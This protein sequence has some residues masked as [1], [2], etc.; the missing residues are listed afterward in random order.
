M[1]V[2]TPRELKYKYGDLNMTLSCVEFLLKFKTE[3]KSTQRNKLPNVNIDE[4]ISSHLQISTNSFL[5]F[6]Q[7]LKN[8]FLSKQG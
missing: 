6:I 7:I 5:T 3:N 8:K 1:A 2:I 4:W